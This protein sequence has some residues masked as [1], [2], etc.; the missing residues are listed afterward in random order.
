L[1]TFEFLDVIQGLSPETV[2]DLGVPQRRDP[3]ALPPRNSFEA[4]M[5]LLYLATASLASGNVLFAIKAA[6][7][8]GWK[9]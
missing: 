8:T 4:S 6:V 1:P 7:L 2:E 3:D 9:A 5:N